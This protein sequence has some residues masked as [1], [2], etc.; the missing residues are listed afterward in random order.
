MKITADQRIAAVLDGDRLASTGRGLVQLLI[1][2]V[3]I[4][5]VILGVRM[6]FGDGWTQPSFSGPA[7]LLFPVV[8]VALG[9]AYAAW[10][11]RTRGRLSLSVVLGIL[12]VILLAGG[13]TLVSQLPE[14][15]FPGPPN[16]VL[17]VAGALIL[18]FGIILGD[19]AGRRLAD[20]AGWGSATWFHRVESLLR[21]RYC[22]T[23]AEARAA[24]A[25]E[26]SA[27][28]AAAASNHP[29]GSAD[30]HEIHAARLA[31]GHRPSI[32]RSVRRNR[33]AWLAAAVAWGVLVGVPAMV[34]GEWFS[35]FAIMTGVVWLLFLGV[36]GARC[37]PIQLAGADRALEHQRSLV[38]RKIDAASVADAAGS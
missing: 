34:S 11:G 15:V 8:T 38:M 14:K 30:N 29:V 7:V 12:A 22:F 21:G 37:R 32:R 10:T 25:R 5:I 23:A 26:R 27:G 3:G 16:W 28:P 36:T 19:G 18:T 6:G 9:L 20:E 1:V 2:S 24:V 13:I 33:F 4:M 17:P 31:T 35:V